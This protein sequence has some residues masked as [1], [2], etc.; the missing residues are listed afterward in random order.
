M[1]H[2]SDPFADTESFPFDGES[3]QTVLRHMF[4]DMPEAVLVADADRRI[5][6]ANAAATDLFRY[7]HDDLLG[8]SSADLYESSADFEEQGR[9][10][11][12]RSAGGEHQSYFMR[13]R[14]GDGSVFDG[15]TIGG[16]IRGTRDAGVMY[17]GIIRDLSSRMAA[18]KAIAALHAITSNPEMGYEKRRGAILEL[19]CRYFGMPIGIVSEIDADRYVIA[20]AIDPNGGLVAGTV[21]PIEDTYCCHVLAAE[22]PFAVDRAGDS[23]ICS[24][25]C[26]RR[27]KLESYI[28][29]PVALDGQVVGTLNFSSPSA[30][31]EFSQTD[32][33]LVG[34]FGQWLSHEMSRERD[35]AALHAAHAELQEAHDRLNEIATLDELT[36]L[37]NRRMLVQQFDREIERGRRYARPLSVALVD[38]DHFK[39]LNDRYGH[40]AGDAALRLFAEMATQ[41]LR[42]A[43][44]IGRWGGEEFLLLLP[45]TARDSAVSSLSRLLERLRLAEFH[46]AGERV[47]LSVSAGVTTSHCDETADAIIRRADEALY[48][49]KADGRDRIA[50]A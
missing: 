33:D 31:G 26:Y 36:G 8:R 30:T 2:R 41:T 19:G 16:A 6:M 25:P 14:R 32:L 12:N 23:K 20:D 3:L 39:R 27:F 34:M 48:R 17:L 44:A 4:A 22:G 13:Y 28:G 10:R 35:L 37:G 50:S 1:I 29:A 45:D 47:P 18:D 49:A 7:Q 5:I 15:E 43:D 46:V 38:F 11:Y 40:A 21:F 9:T 42:G 24:H